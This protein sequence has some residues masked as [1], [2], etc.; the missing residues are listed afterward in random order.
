M[1]LDH[2]ALTEAGFVDIDEA[3]SIMGWSTTTVHAAVKA[4]TLRAVST[5]AGWLVQPAIV[6]H[7]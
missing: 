4:G 5:G 3:A 1:M 7:R 2:G 6:T